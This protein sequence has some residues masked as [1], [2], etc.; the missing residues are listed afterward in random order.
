MR[1]ALRHRHH[2]GAA[3]ETVCGH[4][5]YAFGT[6]SQVDDG[7]QHF[8]NHVAGPG[9]G[10]KR[11]GRVFDLSGRAGRSC[12]GCSGSEHRRKVDGFAR[13][14]RRSAGKT[15]SPYGWRSLVAHAAPRRVNTSYT[16]A[17]QPLTR[18]KVVSQVISLS[19]P[20][21]PDVD[22]TIVGPHGSQ[23]TDTPAAMVVLANGHR[24]SQY[25]HHGPDG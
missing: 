15:S 7:T 14:S 11:A 16:R 18:Q 25:H 1:V 6:I 4:D 21:S 17:I 13:L 19:R 8:G 2:L 10:L 5:E 3:L 12:P 22:S 9:D 20:T 24:G 23:T